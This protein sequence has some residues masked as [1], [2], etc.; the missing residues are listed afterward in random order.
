[1]FLACLMV[2]EGLK[3]G[4]REI[5]SASGSYFS[6]LSSQP[7]WEAQDFQTLSQVFVLCW[8]FL[9]KAFSFKLWIKTLLFLNL[10]AILFCCAFATVLS[11]NLIS[12]FCTQFQLFALNFNFLHCLGLIDMFSANEH[13][14]IFACILLAQESSRW[15]E[16]SCGGSLWTGSQVGYRARRK[17]AWYGSPLSELNFCLHPIPNLGACSQANVVAVFQQ[18][19]DALA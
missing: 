9:F 1:M 18:R 4:P 3:P 6:I 13:A 16:I 12:P 14:E 11:I 7:F 15:W 19:N 8:V 2:W 5:C 10:P 17:I